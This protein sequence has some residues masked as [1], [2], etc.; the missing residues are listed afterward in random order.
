[1]LLLFNKILNWFGYE[2][3][4]T[5]ACVYFLPLPYTED[6]YKVET[7][8]DW[9]IAKIGNWIVCDKETKKLSHKP[10]QHINKEKE[11]TIFYVLGTNDQNKLRD[12]SKKDKRRQMGQA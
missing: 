1:M 5:M 11:F 8:N 10:Y 7:E 6:M 9:I 4:N 2:L 12:G 3:H